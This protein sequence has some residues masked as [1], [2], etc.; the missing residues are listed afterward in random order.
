M[1]ASELTDVREQ[2]STKSETLETWRQYSLLP[3][4]NIQSFWS[5]YI[6]NTLHAV[7]ENE[8]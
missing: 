2:Y 5:M 6:L 3:E 7:A 8:E 1:N 4:E